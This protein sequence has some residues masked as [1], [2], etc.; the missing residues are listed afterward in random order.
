MCPI[1]SL[2]WPQSKSKMHF[3]SKG[4]LG[5][6]G[7]IKLGILSFVGE[8]RA[9][10]EKFI[11]TAIAAGVVAFSTGTATAIECQPSPA[12]SDGNHWAWRQID[13]EKCWYAGEPRMEKSK[14]RWPVNADP[15]REPTAEMQTMPR[16]TFRMGL[17][18]PA[19]D[20]NF[21]SPGPSASESAPRS[22]LAE[23]D[24]VG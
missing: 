5:L 1:C 20:T 3:G 6:K 9:R 16:S 21:G 15:V 18:L 2:L 12:I 7:K 17:A 13:N 22:I 19:S 14:L 11:R 8:K 4:Y 23:S 24:G 10:N